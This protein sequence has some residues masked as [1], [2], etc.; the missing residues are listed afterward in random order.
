MD[1]EQKDFTDSPPSEKK[2]IHSYND[3]DD[4]NEPPSTSS[5]HRGLN[6]RQIG[7]IALVRPFT[8]F[9][10]LLLICHRVEQLVQV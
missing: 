4:F 2:S 10:A 8:F 1:D 3:S 7:M 6:A 5:L 9:V